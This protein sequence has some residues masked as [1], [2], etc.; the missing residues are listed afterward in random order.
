L[1]VRKN[2]RGTV[3]FHEQRSR[4]WT[5]CRKRSYFQGMLKE[6]R[7]DEKKAFDVKIRSGLSTMR[8]YN[9]SVTGKGEG[10]NEKRF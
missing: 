8:G 2:C 9:T 4:E 7:R 3:E 10:E 6:E 5:G 1:R